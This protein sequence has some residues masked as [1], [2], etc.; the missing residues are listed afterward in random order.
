MSDHRRRIRALQALVA[1][2][3]LASD[4][5]YPQIDEEFAEVYRVRLVRRRNRRRLLQ[6]LHSTRALDS[7]LKVFV[8]I[9]GLSPR[10]P[11]LG[12]YLWELTNHNQ[13]RLGNLPEADRRRYQSEIVDLR[14]EF[15][16]EAGA[17]P[18][19]D[20]QIKVLLSDMHSCLCQVLSL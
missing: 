14:N 4:S 6:V 16:H 2:S 13:S 5:L 18:P 15:M 1:G 20:Q 9:F 17:F 3:I 10:N 11:S 7:S 19:D 12:A 8:T